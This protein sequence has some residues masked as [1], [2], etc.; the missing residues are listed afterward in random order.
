MHHIPSLGY[1]CTRSPGQVHALAA[2]GDARTRCV[3]IVDF[4]SD[5]LIDQLIRNNVRHPPRHTEPAA[6]SRHS[7]GAYGVGVGAGSRIG[8][9]G[10]HRAGP[11]SIGVESA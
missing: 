1:P 2:W 7:G 11:A 5:Y 6:G 4:L 9:A 10:A 8:L 3:V